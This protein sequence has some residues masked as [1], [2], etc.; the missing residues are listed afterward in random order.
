MNLYNIIIVSVFSLISGAMLFVMKSVVST[1]KDKNKI[2]DEERK[3]FQSENDA[4]IFNQLSILT[5]KM[6][7]TYKL[8]ME[9][10]AELPEKFVTRKDYDKHLDRETET[11]VDI[12]R[13][14]DGVYSG[15]KKDNID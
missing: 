8:L 6:E 2:I 1:F 10:M 5:K 12:H 14:L 13:R 9:K 7:D 15:K 4:R 11:H 3:Q